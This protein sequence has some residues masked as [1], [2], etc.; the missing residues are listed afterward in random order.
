MS[1]PFLLDEKPTVV[2]GGSAGERSGARA[3]GPFSRPSLA[4]RASGA[5]RL[6]LA[7]GFRL[8]RLSGINR[9]AAQGSERR[10]RLALATG[11]RLLRL[12]GIIESLRRGA[13][14]GAGA[15]LFP[16]CLLLC[17]GAISG[18]TNLRCCRR[19]RFRR[20]FESLFWS[21]PVPK[22][23]YTELYKACR[24]QKG[25]LESANPGRGPYDSEV[26]TISE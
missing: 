19:H 15:G 7:T 14:R 12:S 18:A 5:S 22:R 3:K 4:L 24:F 25:R 10:R 2:P 17:S 16:W 21:A 23:T 11:F 8:L 9:I 13:W 1:I 20:D 6:A 26:G